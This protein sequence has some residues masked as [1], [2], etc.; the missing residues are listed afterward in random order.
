[1]CGIAATFAYGPDA[2][3]VDREELLCMRERMFSRGPDGAGEWF[4]PDGRVGLAHRRLS[5]IDLS[6]A[7]AQPMWNVDRT[8]AIVFN[9]EIYNYAELRTRLI[10]SGS[11]FHS[12][13]D[14]EVLLELY[15]TR[16]EAMLDQLRGMY[17]FVIWDSRKRCVFAARDPFGIKPLFYSDNGRTI[18]FASQVKALLCNKRIDT[19]PDPAGH[20][21]FFIWGSVPEPH[22]LYRGIRSLAAGHTLTVAENESATIEPYCT[23]ADLLASGVDAAGDSERLSPAELQHAIADSVEHHLVA[24]V[25]V[26]VFLSSGLDS[27]TLAAFARHRHDQVK[28]VTLGF[29]EYRGTPNDEV[30][31]A[32]ET[33]RLLGTDHQTIWVS[34][35]DFEAESDRLFDAMD[36][37]SIDGVNTYFVSL[38]ARRAGL[39]VALSGLGADELFGGYES[40]R[41]IPRTARLLSPLDDAPWFG[42]AFRKLAAASLPANISPKYAGVFEY[43]SSV[44]GAYLLRRA[45]FMPWELETVLPPEM[46]REGWEQLRAL[47]ALHQTADRAR[48]SDRLKISALEITVYMRNQLLRDA[49]WA[50]MAHSVEIRV[51]FVDKALLL[52]LAGSLASANPAT[53]QD[54]ARSTPTPLPDAVLQ[55]PK[56]GFVTPVREWLLHSATGTARAERGLRAWAREVYTRV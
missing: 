52:R 26:G 42:R 7:G 36:Q 1:M 16:G 28:T 35:E 49:D 41:Q 31:L 46:V 19:M 25:P 34:R 50:G 30:P 47:P 11:I 2:P 24:D 10:A 3:P 13:C 29:H 12:H 38:A 20:V 48:L 54:M 44:A 53:K 55:R 32:E 27:S 40:F 39:K 6:D 21:G 8:I 9:G 43:G 56:T 18:R 4:S 17:A 5:I 15:A 33:A 45:L 51:P 37:P 14:T 23:V 22:T